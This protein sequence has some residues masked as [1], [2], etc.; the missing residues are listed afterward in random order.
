MKWLRKFNS[1]NIK[2]CAK[3]KEVYDF[4]A[5]YL[6][7]L[8]FNSYIESENLY[9]VCAYDNDLLVG[10]SIFRMKDDKI[11][12]NYGVVHESYRNKG[13]NKRMKLKI[14]EIGRKNNCNIITS[15]VRESNK[16]SLKSQQNIGFKIND[17]VDLKYKDGEKKIALYLNL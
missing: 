4:V 11:H 6:D 5:S 9:Q 15:N 17:R 2:E 7:I 16:A 14:I 13:I 12:M 1:I 3:S 10:A 8:D